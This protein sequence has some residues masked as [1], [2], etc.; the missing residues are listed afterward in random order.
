MQ[1]TQQAND[2]QFEYWNGGAGRAWVEMRPVLDRVFEPFTALL[3]SNI[4][5]ST[6]NVLDIGCGAGDTTLAIARSLHDRG[7]ATGVDISQPLI[8]AA[9]RRAS[10]ES[11]SATFIC[12]DAGTYPFERASFD[13]L[14][15]RF[16]VMFFN[17]PVRAFANLQRAVRPNAELRCLVWRGPEENPFMTTGE[18]AARPFLPVIPCRVPD[19]PGQF[20]FADKDRVTSILTQSNWTSIDVRP[21]QVACAFPANELTRYFTNLGPLGRA[22]EGVTDPRRAE[23]IATVRHA[24]DSFVVGDQVRFEAACWMVTARSATG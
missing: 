14:I 18:R 7:R 6:R 21:H 10:D 9:Q 15:S 5:E 11:V 20:A 17:E 2:D 13:L 23:I 24:F 22:L 19:A 3:V 1:H 16:G 8:A 4:P 12:A